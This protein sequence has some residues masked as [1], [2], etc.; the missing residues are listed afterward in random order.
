MANNISKIQ[1]GTDPDTAV[2]YDIYDATAR[3][4]A[5][6]ANENATTANAWINDSGKKG[7]SS[8][9]DNV[10]SLWITT[11]IN[12]DQMW[13]SYR[14]QEANEAKCSDH[15]GLTLNF[16][17]KKYTNYVKTANIVNTRNEFS[18]KTDNVLN[19]ANRN[20]MLISGYWYAHYYSRVTNCNLIFGVTNFA[21]SQPSDKTNSSEDT[22]LVLFNPYQNRQIQGSGPLIF[23]T[24]NMS[25]TYYIWHSVS[26]AQKNA[27]AMSYAGMNLKILY[28][29]GTVGW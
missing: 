1:I 21:T 16:S 28:F 13:G 10:S 24:N 2:V 23:A 18:K 20:Y 8:H 15:G 29:G 4:T 19:C 5:G 14:N 6:T 7:I 9:I 17:S 26:S 12:S 11:A 25:N 27:S 22:R 3:A